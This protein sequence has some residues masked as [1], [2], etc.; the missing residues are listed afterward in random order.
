[1]AVRR[2]AKKL[3][4]VASVKTRVEGSEKVGFP[5]VPSPLVIVIWFAVPVSVRAET[6]DVPFDES[7]PIK[8]W[9]VTAPLA[10]RF[11]V[12]AVTAVSIVVE[13]YGA[14]R[15]AVDGRVREPVEENVEVAVPP[16]YAVPVLEKRVEEALANVERPVNEEAPVTFSVPAVARLPKESIVVE[17]V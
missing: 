2:P 6:P 10:I 4:E 15:R 17:A 3:V 12:E 13:A 16:K 8:F 11:V 14:V 9:K 5:P 1:L 7:I